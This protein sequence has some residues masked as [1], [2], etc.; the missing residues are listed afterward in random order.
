[1]HSYF[2]TTAL[3]GILGLSGIQIAASQ[4]ARN[5]YV[6]FPEVGQPKEG[7]LWPMGQALPTF[8][9]PS[10]SLDA[11]DV[12]SLSVDEQLAFA[13]LQGIVN[14]QQPR[15]L[16]FDSRAGEGGDTW[17][18]TKGVDFSI[19]R[20]FEQRERYE[21]MKKYRGEVTGVVL[22][23]AEKSEHYRNLASSVAGVEQA[24]PV[25]N[26]LWA[27]L[28]E[29]GIGLEVFKDLRSLD[30]SGPIEIYEHLYENYW[31][32]CSKR[33]I[34][35][36]RPDTRGGDHHHT[37]D[38]AAAT[39][40]AVIWLDGRIPEERELMG[41]FLGEMKAGEAIILGWYTTERSGITT[42]SAYGIGTL[43]ADYFV[44][45][46]VFAGTSPRIEVPP[47]P[48]VP[49]LSNKVYVALF[50]S[51]GDNIQYNQHAMRIVW[52]RERETRGK[53][54]LTWTIS[55][56]LVDIAPGIMNYYY[57]TATAKDCFATGPSGMG[58]LI[59]CNTLIEDGAPLGAFAVDRGRMD[60][61]TRLTESYLQR[62][63]LRVVTIWDNAN[64]VQRASYEKNCRSLI[65]ATVQNFKDVPSVRGGVSGGRVRFD[66]LVIPYAGSYEHLKGSLQE[67][68]GRWD[69]EGPHFL[70]Y[71]VDIWGRLK[72]KI[73]VEIA[74]EMKAEFGEQ[75]EFI[76]GDHYFNLSNQA[77]RVPFDISLT[78]EV[79][80]SCSEGA[81]DAALANDGTP[82]T[83]WCSQKQGAWLQFDLGKER[84]LRRYVIRHAG[85]AGLS[86]SL[87]TRCFSV[88]GSLDGVSWSHIDKVTGNRLN[89]WDRELEGEKLR[90]FRIKIEDAGEDGVARVAEV[91]LY[92]LPTD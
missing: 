65:G 84:E 8:A 7:I 46:T 33:M 58:Y 81:D 83:I 1:M 71:Q 80:V 55:P 5:R 79:S 43:P 16:L 74:R 13:A 69:G 87:N 2:K 68:L 17:A 92:C 52:D 54:P 48:K 22:Y 26:K 76:R 85:S 50:I 18:R 30:C 49:R 57:R 28:V 23:D 72:P 12:R 11:I 34:V 27:R 67:E 91:E 39:G 42:A 10:R 59:P 24:L 31:P 75:V 32:R 25:S 38:M 21:L 90:Y 66:K 89:A 44:S 60:G 19:G 14:R 40:S 62:S 4:D 45:S 20:I 77:S 3:W 53:V 56:S 86:R 47:V 63:G 29:E 51:D 70:A 41:K 88:E 73:L 9:A 35:S 78:D 82:S 37:R 6:P 36:A 64:S 61:Y 15:I